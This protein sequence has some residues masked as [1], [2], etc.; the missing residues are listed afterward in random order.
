MA[1]YHEH[2]TQ[3]DDSNLTGADNTELAL[4]GLLAAFIGVS[5]A[6]LSWMA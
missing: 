4:I 2:D 3:H 6:I 1:I 5:V